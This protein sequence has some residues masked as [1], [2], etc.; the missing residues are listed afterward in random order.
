MS[1]GEYHGLIYGGPLAAPGAEVSITCSIA[2]NDGS[3]TAPAVVSE[4]AGPSAHAVALVPTP[5]SYAA[6]ISDVPY[7][8]STATVDGAAWYRDEDAG[9]VHVADEPFWDCPP[10][11]EWR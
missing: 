5:M 9:D 2:L 8:C 1:P 11:D 4:S 6:E 7:L 3:R 10:Y